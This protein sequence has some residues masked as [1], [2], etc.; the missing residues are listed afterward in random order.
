MAMTPQALMVRWEPL[1]KEASRR[2][3]VPPEWIRAVIRMESGGRQWI[4]EGVPTLSDMGAMGIMQVL[5]QTYAEMRVQYGLGN[6][7]YDPHDNVI[8]GTAYLKWLYGKYGNPAMFAAYNDGPGNLE[9]FLTNAREL[10]AQTHNYVAGIGRLIGQP[11]QSLVRLTKVTLTR[12]D[13]SLIEVDSR[14]VSAVRAASPGEYA[15]GVAT[16]VSMGNKK[17]GVKEDAAA[18]AAALRAKGAKI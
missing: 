15:S 14:E 16:V 11:G 2:F 5:P 13:G 8:A 3:D 1:V 17:Q 18:V 9:A 6:D 10:P 7:P 4:G 12:P